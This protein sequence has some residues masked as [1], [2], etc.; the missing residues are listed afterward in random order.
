MSTKNQPLNNYILAS[1]NNEHSLFKNK[2]FHLNK[3]EYHAVFIQTTNDIAPIIKEEP[4]V[5]DL[6]EKIHFIDTVK[7]DRNFKE[8][9]SDNCYGNPISYFLTTKEH[10]LLE[11][12]PKSFNMYK[13]TFISLNHKELFEE[14]DL[15]RL[16][17]EQLKEIILFSSLEQ[18]NLIC[19]CEKL[20]NKTVIEALA[21]RYLAFFNLAFGSMDDF[22]FC[23]A[24]CKDFFDAGTYSEIQQIKSILDLSFF[25]VED[26]TLSL[27]QNIHN[28]S[29]PPTDRFIHICKEND[30]DHDDSLIIISDENESKYIEHL[31]NLVLDVDMSDSDKKV[32]LENFNMHFVN[33]GNIS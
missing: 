23:E 10:S 15:I 27:L 31:L 19:K 1:E 11:I 3:D 18:Y 33:A 29:I 20:H 14:D 22:D 13:S 12:T 5:Q 17:E 24:L 25:V 32:S 6:S 4:S 16:N 7:M 8:T 26:E 2:G 9:L 30:V 28:I 21:I